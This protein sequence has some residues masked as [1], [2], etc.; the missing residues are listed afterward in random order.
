MTR[1]IDSLASLQKRMGCGVIV[2]WTNHRIDMANAFAHWQFPPPAV[3]NTLLNFRRKTPA[4]QSRW[5][6]HNDRKVGHVLRDDATRPHHRAES[7]AT[8]ARRND[9]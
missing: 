1:I 9:Y 3:P 2:Q 5:I 4:D 6:A 7:N 8:T